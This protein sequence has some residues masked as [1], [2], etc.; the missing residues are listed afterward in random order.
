MVAAL[1][2]ATIHSGGSQSLAN[3]NLDADPRDPYLVSRFKLVPAQAFA[4]YR[5]DP[6]V[7]VF[8]PATI[9]RYFVGFTSQ[10]AGAD[11]YSRASGVRRVVLDTPGN[12]DLSVG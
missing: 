7:V 2:L 3:A 12:S 9:C 10:G 5:L 6:H 8:C 11:L 4:I 1:W